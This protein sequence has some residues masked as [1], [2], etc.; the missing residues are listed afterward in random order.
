MKKL[1][2]TLLLFAALSSKGQNAKVDDKG[3]YTAIQSKG[4]ETKKTFTDTKG[5]VFPLLESVN[6][7]LYYLKT[8]KK[9]NQYK[10]YLKLEK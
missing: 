9:G 2:I 6:G 4:K 3:N 8:S 1:A 10:V 7:K 5:N